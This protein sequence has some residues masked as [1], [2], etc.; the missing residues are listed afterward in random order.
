MILSVIQNDITLNIKK[1][2]K[3]RDKPTANYTVYPARIISTHL[4]KS[5]IYKCQII[6]SLEQYHMKYNYEHTLDQKVQ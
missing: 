6:L 3:S 1:S 5:L 2:Q 4:Q